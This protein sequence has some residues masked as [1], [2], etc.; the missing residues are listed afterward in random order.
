MAIV[1][2]EKGALPPQNGKPDNPAPAPSVQRSHRRL[3]ERVTSL[4]HRRAATAPVTQPTVEPQQSLAEPIAPPKEPIPV[5][6]KAPEPE[7]FMP[8]QWISEVKQIPLEKLVPYLMENVDAIRRTFPNP[9]TQEASL[10]N[11][12]AANDLLREEIEG[13]PLVSK[14]SMLSEIREALQVL[15]Q[16]LRLDAATKPE[17]RIKHDDELNKALYVLGRIQN[18]TGEKRVKTKNMEED[19]TSQDEE[20]KGES[21]T[22]RTFAVVNEELEL[23]KENEF[24]RTPRPFGFLES[25]ESNSFPDLVTNWEKTNTKIIITSD[26]LHWLNE[27]QGFPVAL[28]RVKMTLPNTGKEQ[29]ILLGT[30]I[31]PGEIMAELKNL[32]EQKK[33]MVKAENAFF[34]DLGLHIEG[35]SNRRLHATKTGDEVFIATK[36]GKNARVYY[37]QP[38]SID[39]TRVVVVIGA[40]KKS[41]EKTIAKS[42]IASK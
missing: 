34:K 19:G 16:G 22:P 13:N 35:R 14:P 39:G 17:D 15:Q 8:N 31:S 37:I 7:Q 4:L 30:L 38:G 28:D 24:K 1:P 20:T 18:P 42:V 25:R 9:Q 12:K 5:K 32:A 26:H 27:K 33:E 23:V 6:T 29:E 41:S 11:L 21:D 3:F 2:P 40:Y 10:N 36:G